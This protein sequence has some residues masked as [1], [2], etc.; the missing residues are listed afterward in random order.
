MT[1]TRDI[2]PFFAH[3]IY[4]D[5]LKAPRFQDGNTQE[6]DEPFR[7][8]K[9]RVILLRRKTGRALVLG[10]WVHTG[11]EE[12]EALLRAFTHEGFGGIEIP[13]YRPGEEDAARAVI[14]RHATDLDDEWNIIEHLGLSS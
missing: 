10:K 5:P 14:A 13:D 8:S 2:G 3:T 12:E 1:Q 7:R 6:T 11:F 9:S 4:L